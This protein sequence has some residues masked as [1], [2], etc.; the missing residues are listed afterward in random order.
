MIDYYEILGVERSASSKEI[1]KAYIRQC[2]RWHPDRIDAKSDPQGWTKANARF[3]LINDA[4]KTLKEPLA[5]R[6]YDEQWVS[7]GPSPDSKS[8]SPQKSNPMQ[9]TPQYVRS[10]QPH[11]DLRR[12][13]DIA[14]GEYLRGLGLGKGGFWRNYYYSLSLDNRIAVAL[15]LVMF[16]YVLWRI[17]FG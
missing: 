15:M 17:F 12:R 6:Q 3:Q 4:H 14:V 13:S 8:P 2:K 11:N 9:N 5:R 1:R 7:R 10:T 16:L